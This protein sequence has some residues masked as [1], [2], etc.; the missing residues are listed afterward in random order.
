M[1]TR[2]D[3][4]KRLLAAVLA[5]AAV[6]ILAGVVLFVVSAPTSVL[7]FVVQLPAFIL[8]SWWLG[9]LSAA[10]VLFALQRT[11]R[12]HLRT[13]AS[14]LV[15]AVLLYVLIQHEPL[16]AWLLPAVSGK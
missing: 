1:S 4:F 13:A 15:V 16:V 3:L 10:V 12:S 9:L 2:A 6:T 11:S 14:T 5:G 7:R 8:R